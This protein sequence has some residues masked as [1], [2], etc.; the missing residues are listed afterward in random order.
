M[1]DDQW[2]VFV[3]ELAEVVHRCLVILDDWL[4]KHYGFSRRPRGKFSRD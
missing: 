1:T 4:C 2:T 3:A